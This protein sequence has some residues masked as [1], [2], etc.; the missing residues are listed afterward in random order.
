MKVASVVCAAC[1]RM[2]GEEHNS[3]CPHVYEG[4]HLGVY[5]DG[6]YAGRALAYE[7]AGLCRSKLS[8]ALDACERELEPETVRLVRRVCQAEGLL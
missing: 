7:V 5:E 1:A 2:H 3:A 8:K 4:E 6:W